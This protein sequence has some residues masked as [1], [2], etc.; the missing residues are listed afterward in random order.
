MAY[1][2]N[3]AV[4]ELVLVKAPHLPTAAGQYRLN[5]IRPGGP[6]QR[7]S[8]K[9]TIEQK[10]AAEAA[11]TLLGLREYLSEETGWNSLDAGDC[12]DDELEQWELGKA[13]LNLHVEDVEA[14]RGM[15]LRALK[16]TCTGSGW[17]FLK[18]HSMVMFH[19]D[20]RTDDF[21]GG[22]SRYADKLQVSGL[23]RC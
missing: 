17:R 22:A 15:A 18:N 5:I 21:T 11:R 19:S 13:L 10:R 2:Q 3:K 1:L 12:F 20:R 16:E 23:T 9:D 6:K 14:W 7:R 4:K 8:P